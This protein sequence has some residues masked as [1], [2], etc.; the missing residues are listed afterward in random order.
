[1]KLK[2]V[3]PQAALPQTT[4]ILLLTPDVMFQLNTLLGTLELIQ[5][6]HT[7]PLLHDIPS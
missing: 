2:A 4:F 7:G 6:L 5:D 1:M 3:M